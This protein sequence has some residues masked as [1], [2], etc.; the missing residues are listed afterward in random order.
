MKYTEGHFT[1]MSS[2]S[3]CQFCKLT[4]C[5]EKPKTNADIIRTMSDE[6]LADILV[7][8]DIYNPVPWCAPDG[9]RHMDMDDVPCDQC[10]LEWLRQEVTNA[11]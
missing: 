7:G 11:D 8:N 5:A 1:D 2:T 9:C 10:A 3:T 4:K 6:M